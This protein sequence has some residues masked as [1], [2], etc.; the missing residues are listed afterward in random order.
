MDPGTWLAGIKIFRVT[1][2][3]GD[4]GVA[5]VMASWGNV[6]QSRLAWLPVNWSIWGSAVSRGFLNVDGCQ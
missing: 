5:M 1:E 3:R 4:F 2:T 6:G